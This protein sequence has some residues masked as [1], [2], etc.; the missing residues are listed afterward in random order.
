[1]DDA[2]E[3]KDGFAAPKMENLSGYEGQTIRQASC[4]RGPRPNMN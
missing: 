2:V 1:L 4:M 3:K